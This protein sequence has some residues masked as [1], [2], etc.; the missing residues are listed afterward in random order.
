VSKDII[1]RLDTEAQMKID[2]NEDG[3]ELLIDASNEIER[4][5]FKVAVWRRIAELGHW[6]SCSRQTNDNHKECLERIYEREFR[7]G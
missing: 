6:A 2:H 5:L 4:L 1:S 7:G 3:F